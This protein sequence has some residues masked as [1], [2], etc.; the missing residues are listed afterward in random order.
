MISKIRMV[1]VI[2]D[3]D[4]TP[5]FKEG[6]AVQLK[7]KESIS[8]VFFDFF[9]LFYV[10]VLSGHLGSVYDGQ[11]KAGEEKPQRCH[12]LGD[13]ECVFLSHHSDC[14]YSSASGGEKKE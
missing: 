10:C 14:Q 6:S 8:Y 13:T 11:C 7:E 1:T 4:G 3:Q 12:A 5:F 2:K 9:A